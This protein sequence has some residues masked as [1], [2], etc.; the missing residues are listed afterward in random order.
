MDRLI[1]VTCA[2]PRAVGNGDIL[3]RGEIEAIKAQ[4]NAQTDLQRPVESI[5]MEFV[6][7]HVKDT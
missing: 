1:A 2:T 6:K 3:H 5:I 4:V 7:T